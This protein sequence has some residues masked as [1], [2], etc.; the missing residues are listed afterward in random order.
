M[1]VIR[2]REDRDLGACSL[3][4]RAAHF[5]DGYP[6]RLPD[7]P[8][9]FLWSHQAIAGWVAELDGQVVGHVALHNSSSRPV[10]ELACQATRL[11][12]SSFGVVARLVVSPTARHVGIG[13]ALLTTAVA[14]ARSRGLVPILDVRKEATAAIRLYEAAGWISLGQITVTFEDGLTLDELVYLSPTAPA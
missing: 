12:A 1:T 10:I 4:V 5:Q 9:V 7:D 13:Q 6:A 2:E 11:P 3:L 8:G 14:H